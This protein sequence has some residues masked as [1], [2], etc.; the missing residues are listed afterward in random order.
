MTAIR[1]KKIRMSVDLT[2][3]LNDVVEKLAA[4]MGISKSEVLKRGIALL[5]GAEDHDVQVT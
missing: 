4:R 2:G 1:T 3:D 5:A